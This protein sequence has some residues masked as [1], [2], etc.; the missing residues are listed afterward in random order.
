VLLLISDLLLL[1]LEQRSGLNTTV[2]WHQQL[3]EGKQGL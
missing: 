2:S 3:S 1:L